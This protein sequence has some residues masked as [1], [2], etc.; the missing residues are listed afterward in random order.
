M[1]KDYLRRVLSNLLMLN[2]LPCDLVLVRHGESEGNKAKKLQ[3]VFKNILFKNKHSSQWRATD[4]GRWQADKAGIYIRQNIL[5]VIPGGKFFRKYCASYIR[6]LETA[7]HLGLGGEWLESFYLRERDWGYLDVM[8]KAE[9][10][11]KFADA[12]EFMKRSAFL[13][14]PPNGESIANLCIRLSLMNGTIGRECPRKP[15]IMVCHG[16]VMW[17][18]RVLLERIPLDRYAILDDSKEDFD[19]MHNCQILWYTRRDPQTGKMEKYFRWM[20]SVC[21]WDTT[22]SS[23]EWTEI[24]RPR[25]TDEQL[26]EKAAA[27]KQIVF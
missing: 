16:E 14:A 20:K 7:A 19:K 3:D 1:L 24:V 9:R 12:L 23:N 11:E 4:I 25:F 22:L 5:P 17:A 21:P 18:Q 15:V 27:V 10:Q 26:L 13:N 2:E 8:S 6:A